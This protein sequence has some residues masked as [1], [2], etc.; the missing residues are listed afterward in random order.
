MRTARVRSFVSGP[1]V[2]KNGGRLTFARTSGSARVADW[3]WRRP[4]ASRCG[5]VGATRRSVGGRR[6]KMDAGKGL[7]GRQGPAE[8][9]RRV[10]RALGILPERPGRGE[11][12]GRLAAPGGTGRG[13]VRGEALWI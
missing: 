9:A 3:P 10:P 4:V 8:D 12:G 5:P 7:P 11:A 13:C 2:R 1:A 6:G